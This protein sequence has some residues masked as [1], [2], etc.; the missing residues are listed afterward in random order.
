MKRSTLPSSI[1]SL[2]RR[3]LAGSIAASL[4]AI[5]AASAGTVL[6]FFG[7]IPS[8]G[9]L[10]NRTD[11][12]GSP[13]VDLNSDG[14]VFHYS[15]LPFSS[16]GTVTMEAINSNL[17]P[18][19]FDDT[20][21]TLYKNAFN[22][23]SPLTNAVVD[24][25]D[26]GVHYLSLI[27][28]DLAPGQKYIL[29]VT[30]YDDYVS[31]PYT[32]RMSGPN[33]IDLEG[34]YDGSLAIR[35][36]IFGGNGTITG[37]LFNYGILNPGHSPG[38][39][40]VGN[41]YVQGPTGTLRIEIGGRHKGEF[42]RLSVGG[43]AFL[44]GGLELVR[45]N[46]FHLHRGDKITF[47][48]A[49]GGIQGEFASV[50]GDFGNS[51]IQYESHSVSV[52]LPSY[53]D[54]ASTYGFT[55]NQTAVSHALDS[56]N[57]CSY[58]KLF[59]FLD[60]RPISKLPGDL[61]RIAPEEITSVF[62]MGMSLA[63]VQSGNVGR[64]NDDIRNG[65]SGFS[66]A[67]LAVNGAGP[68]YSGGFRTGVAGPNGNEIRDDGKAVKE[69]QPL[70]AA[71]NRWGAFLAGTGEWVSVGNTD[72]A[73]GY[74]LTSGGFTLGVDYK[75]T[76]N[77]AIGLAAGYTGTT[78]DLVD[79]GR[80]YVNGG[81][82]GIYGTY[83]QTQPEAVAPTMSKD[84]SKDSKAVQPATAMI[85]K[86]FYADAAVFGGYNGYS[87]RRAG[88]EGEARGD[89]DGGELNVLVGAGYDFKFGALTIGPTASFNY[90]YVGTNGY[91][92]NGSLAPLAIHGG[93]AE[94]LRTAFGIK[95][96][97]DWK[98]GS[99]LIRPE[100]R[101]AWQHEFGDTAYE[102]TSDFGAGDSFT[103]NGPQVG[104]DSAL[105]GAGFAVQFNE[106]FTTYFYYDGELGRKTYESHA[107]TGGVRVAF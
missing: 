17:S 9:P 98:C 33:E 36:G 101:A 82:I 71:E 59:N 41:D 60:N 52:T 47:L 8:N 14:T 97:Y 21:F 2:R 56:L 54:I 3:I 85:A 5:S 76:P 18:G 15:T 105:L 43:H 81:K 103:V 68:S 66:A 73:R 50:F 53:S 13:V 46:D 4:C 20:Y 57:V 42:D 45:T 87:M 69:T 75:I 88:L 39:I 89:T 62:S 40:T 70:V 83:Y 44:D 94:S 26:G 31:G 24:N 23:G 63:Q 6:D 37:T 48:T 91:N 84:S 102:L 86:G 96:S 1:K 107:V 12:G 35:S 78:A 32:L 90:T 30:T 72:N 28:Q 99:V 92:E 74:D 27:S 65:T 79:R 7:K 25:D 55:K 67:G 19:D 38:K 77:L 16:K 10:F 104:R 51:T 64:R 11:T 49:G 58:Q 22:P 106:R 80:V 93:E 95:A 61:D 34:T 29:V 100:V